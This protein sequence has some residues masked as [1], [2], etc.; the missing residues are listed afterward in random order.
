MAR[1][2]LS[3]HHLTKGICSSGVREHRPPPSFSA[4]H[5][6][7]PSLW[8]TLCLLSHL[9]CAGSVGAPPSDNVT[10]EAPLTSCQFCELHPGLS[11]DPRLA[12]PAQWHLL[13]TAAEAESEVAS[14]RQQKWHRQEPPNPFK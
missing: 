1:T 4:R 12:A 10:S 2:R 13:Q 7:L 11:V 14:L 5:A 9:K 6:C 8:E 3:R